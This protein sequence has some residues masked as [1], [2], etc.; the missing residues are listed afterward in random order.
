[1][2]ELPERH[3]SFAVDVAKKRIEVFHISQEKLALAIDVSSGTIKHIEAGKLPATLR[4]F[5]R[6]CWYLGLNP[7][8]YAWDIMRELCGIDTDIEET[9]SEMLDGAA[10]VTPATV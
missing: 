2:F 6:V 5:G 9:L 3:H 4:V 8:N 1:M 7:M 10:D